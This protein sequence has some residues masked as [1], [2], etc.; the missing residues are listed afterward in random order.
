MRTAFATTS[1][2]RFHVLASGMLIVFAACFV[3]AT[4]ARAAAPAVPEP[5]PVYFDRPLQDAELADMT[6]AELALMRNSGQGV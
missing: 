4:A 5:Q 2:S 6:L 3:G 1:A